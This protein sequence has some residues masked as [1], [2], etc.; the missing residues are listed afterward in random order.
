LRWR[1]QGAGLRRQV[2]PVRWTLLKF[3][4]GCAQKEK[5]KKEKDNA[6]CTLKKKLTSNVI[7]TTIAHGKERLLD[8]VELTT[9]VT[10]RRRGREGY[11][12]NILKRKNMQE[13]NLKYTRKLGRIGTE[14][15]NSPHALEKEILRLRK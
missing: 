7:G 2:L 6:I 15:R 1:G 13:R 14:K 5:R 8:G 11:I 10:W 4:I 3:A 9:F 12:S